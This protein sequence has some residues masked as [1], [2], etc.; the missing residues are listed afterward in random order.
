MSPTT[1]INTDIVKE[2]YANA[3]QTCDKKDMEAQFTY[4]TMVRGTT[5]HFD[6]DTIN[7]YLDNPLTLSPPE[8]P[9]IPTLCEYGQKEEDDEW[10]HN[11]IQRDPI[12][13]KAL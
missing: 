1:Q 2:F 4:T 7:T 5:I 6:R 10:D 8:D 11:V 3:M 9:T 12:T 13:R